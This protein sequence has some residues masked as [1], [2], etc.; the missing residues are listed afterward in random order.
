MCEAHWNKDTDTQVW[1][2]ALWPQPHHTLTKHL[3]STASE[4]ER[5]PVITQF[6]FLIFKMEKQIQRE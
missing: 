5:T 1:V 6:N 4:L 2:L 3:F